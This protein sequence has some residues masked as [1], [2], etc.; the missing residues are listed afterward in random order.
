MRKP[1][2]DGVLTSNDQNDAAMSVKLED[3]NA[4]LSLAHIQSFRDLNDVVLLAQACCQGN[5]DVLDKLVHCGIYSLRKLE[6]L[7]IQATK[8]SE[9][10]QGAD[11]YQ[12]RIRNA[13]E[14]V[15]YLVPE[16]STN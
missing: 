6:G 12:G 13:I 9:F 15:R 3:T 7:Q 4:S 8:M 16:C 2:K 5:F 11:V 10:I 1:L 14:L